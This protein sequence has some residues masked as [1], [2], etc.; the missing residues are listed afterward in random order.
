MVSN[1]LRFVSVIFCIL[2]G[3]V[4]VPSREQVPRRALSPHRA[5]VVCAAAA[6]LSQ[7]SIRTPNSCELVSANVMSVV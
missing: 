7:L 2:R 5:R 4:D 3:K 1:K 6:A